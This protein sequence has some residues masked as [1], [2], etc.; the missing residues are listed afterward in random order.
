MAVL[1]I[2]WPSSNDDIDSGEKYGSDDDYNS[3]GHT[4]PVGVYTKDT[5]STFDLSSHSASDLWFFTT[6]D[7]SQ[8]QDANAVIFKMSGATED[9]FR[10]ICVDTVTSGGQQKAQYYNGSTWVDIATLTTNLTHTAAVRLDIHL[11]LADSGGEFTV[12]VDGASEASFTGDTLLTA[13]TEI[14]SITL[15]GCDGNSS[16]LFVWRPIV[17]A[18][19]DTRGME[20]WSAIPASNGNHT[21]TTGSESSV[22][23]YLYSSGYSDNHAVGDANGERLT[24]NFFDIAAEFSGYSVAAVAVG[25]AA[26]AQSEPGLYIKPLARDASAATDYNPGSSFQPGSTGIRSFFWTMLTDPATASA[27][28]SQA[29]VNDYEFGLEMSSTA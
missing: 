22:D 26:K 24:L 25:I 23:N 7:A 13:D 17:V 29:D 14:D 11:K 28:A 27:W 4:V 20:F 21:E 10:I 15:S 8:D 1:A 18:D 6:V 3:S 16:N 2:R 12:Y 19:A 9:L 5:A